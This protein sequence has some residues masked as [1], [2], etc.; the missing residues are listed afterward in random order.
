MTIYSL[1]CSYFLSYYQFLFLLGSFIYY[2]RKI[3][4]KTILSFPLISKTNIF[5]NGSFNTSLYLYKCISQHA[6][7]MISTTDKIF[8]GCNELFYMTLKILK[9]HFE[10]Q[11]WV[12]LSKVES[13]LE[14]QCFQHF[15]KSCKE[16]WNIRGYKNFLSV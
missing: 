8:Q 12:A 16:K 4:R 9:V 14:F 15:T 13:Y 2:A 7:F 5:L 3:S 6:G 1:S 11:F 10:P